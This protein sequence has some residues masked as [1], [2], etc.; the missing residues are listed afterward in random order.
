L[1]Q[2]NG[3]RLDRVGARHLV[4]SFNKVSERQIKEAVVERS[5]EAFWHEL[6][7]AY[8]RLF[9][10]T[11]DLK[12]DEKESFYVVPPPKAISVYGHPNGDSESKP[13]RKIGQKKIQHVNKEQ[14]YLFDLK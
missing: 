13:K 1:N 9:P 12:G 5:F 7:E 2:F 4:K 10:V 3:L 14:L 8:R 11:A 6:E